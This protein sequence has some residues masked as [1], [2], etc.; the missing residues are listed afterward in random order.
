MNFVTYL[1]NAVS[2]LT[3]KG[4]R[5][6]LKIF[7]LGLGLAIGLVLAS[8]VC[9]EQSY[10]DFYKD[11]SR[12]Y[13]LNE[14][15]VVNGKYEVFSQTSGGVASRIKDHFSQIEEAGRYTRFEE[16][17][18][19]IMSGTQERIGADRV[20]LGDSCILKVLK[21]DLLAGNITSSLGVDG[22]A[23]IS[24]KMALKIADGTKNERVAASQV[25]G[26]KF[27]IASR[28]PE[29]LTI[30]G[31]YE[32]FPLNSSWRPDVII[33]LPSIGRYMYD[34]SDEVIG[35]DR[36]QTFFTLVPH[37]EIEFVNDNF[38]GYME[39][40]LPLEEMKNAGFEMTYMG[41]PIS[42]LH[43][44]DEDRKKESLVLALVASALLFISILNYLLIVISTTV[45]RSR[46]IALRKC[47]GSGTMDTV[48]MMCAESAVHTFLSAALASAII[49]IFRHGIEA[50]LGTGIEGLF[51]GS[52]L[53]LAVCII[54]IVFAINGL[55]PSVLFNR[56]P[57]ANAFRN[58]TSG[59][60][61]WKRALLCI[62][63]GA[64]A[65]LIVLVSIISIQYHNIINADLGFQYENIVKIA[66]P[67]SNGSQ[68]LVF[69]NDVR[70]L[71]EVEDAAFAFSDPFD[72]YNGNNVRLPGSV[73]ELFNIAD[74]YY[75]D[76][77]YFDVLGI[78]IV[79]G[80][81][82]MEGLAPDTEV[83]VDDNFLQLMKNTAGWNE[84][85]G[86]DVSITEHSGE[87][88]N[89]NIVG[90]FKSIKMGSFSKNDEGWNNR[91]C[92]YFY[93][94]PVLYGEKYCY[95]LVKF[96]SLSP[97]SLAAVKNLAEKD[98][99][100]QAV[101]FYPLKEKMIYNYRD[102]LNTRNS[103]MVGSIVI[104]LIAIIGLMG[105]TI[106][107]IKRRSKEI[108][109]RRVNGAQFK[110]IRFMFILDMLN[111]ALPSVIFAS[112]LA[113]LAAKRWEQQFT[114]QAG[115]PWWVFAFAILFT[116]LLVLF[117]TDMN[118]RKTA[119]SNPAESIKT[120]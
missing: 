110:E 61:S 101:Y 14:A 86:R 92:V 115:L 27:H 42:A 24:S 120:E 3:T 36:Y 84:V 68:R 73:Q 19:L 99:P 82:F 79:E 74:A 90:V 18:S 55:L 76:N 62:E 15:A 35:N 72:S 54:L 50:V 11:S 51:T 63:F 12:I 59:K 4:R 89:N 87:N 97:E 52:P 65:F 70:S 44:S 31:V 22:N 32:E 80:R 107:E 25:I 23:V 96:H 46:E 85:L 69:M 28:G 106:D 91:P 94:D 48:K 109:V 8:K 30:T 57:V 114:V 21:R 37:S 117:I 49:I 60:R 88:F 113:G 33:S 116:L 40:Y 104:L 102:T 81:G 103:I 56:I 105:Y 29:E 5:N 53:V 75:V 95:M 108:A 1:C 58:Y 7:T 78:K 26:R 83:I 111:M 38:D 41:K 67:E 93:A 71:S 13:Y 6:G 64:V 66:V 45:V 47:L 17:A 43:Y 10:D 98:L 39:T 9:F 2:S 112:V 77:H 100:G 16:E 119:S 20:F 118:V 34:G